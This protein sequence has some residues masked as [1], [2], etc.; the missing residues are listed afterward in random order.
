MSKTEK[1]QIPDFITTYKLAERMGKPK[2]WL[3]NRLNGYFVNGK[4]CEFTS[5]DLA[6]MKNAF[7][8]M[9]AELGKEADADAVQLI[10]NLVSAFSFDQPTP[11]PEQIKALNEAQRFLELVKNS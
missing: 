4:K 8:S 1:V 3:Y 10:E 11:T 6:L 7:L 2:Q 5:E 9:W